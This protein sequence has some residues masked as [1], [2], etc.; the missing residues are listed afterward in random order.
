MPEERRPDP[1]PAHLALGSAG[2][3]AVKRMTP[4]GQDAPV[5][6]P[7]RPIITIVLDHDGHATV[8]GRAV[9]VEH[10]EDP[11][12][13]LLAMASRRAALL[14]RPVRVEARDPDGVWHLAAHPDG[15]VTELPPLP[16]VPERADDAGLWQ[17]RVHPSGEIT[18]VDERLPA[19]DPAQEP[20]PPLGQHG[21]RVPDVDPASLLGDDAPPAVDQV[22]PAVDGDDRPVDDE[23][24]PVDDGG[25]TPADAP[26]SGGDRPAPDRLWSTRPVPGPTATGRS[27]SDLPDLPDLPEPTPDPVPGSAAAPVPDAPPTPM[28]DHWLSMPVDDAPPAVDDGSAAVDEL[29]GVVDGTSELVDDGTPGAGPPSVANQPDDGEQ[30]WFDSLEEQPSHR[31]G[32]SWTQTGDRRPDDHPDGLIDDLRVANLSDPPADGGRRPWLRPVAF[33]GAG[34]VAV[35]AIAA[36]LLTGR[37]PLSTTAQRPTL[38]QTAQVTLG[39]PSGP[40]AADPAPASAPPTLA[41]PPSRLSIGPP[42]GYG[43]SPVWALPISPSATSIVSADGRVLTLTADNQV[44]LVDPLTGAVLWH[45]PVPS[46]AAGPFFSRV[47]GQ[48]VAAVTTEKRLTYWGLPEAGAQANPR[49]T[50]I[51][52]DLPPGTSVSWAGPSP[53]LALGDGGTGVIRSGAIQRVTLP[54]GMRGLAADGADVLAVSGRNWIRQAAGQAP[55]QP[56]QFAAPDGAT[57]TT[58]VRIDNVGGSFL[59]TMWEGAQGPVVAVYDA[60][61][62]DKV[63]QSTFPKGVDFSRA[64]TVREAG[65]E[66]TTVGS[67]LIE[68]AQHNLSVLASSFTPVALTPGHVFADGVSGAVADLQISGK[69]LKV[70]RF[71]DR[72]PTVPVGIVTRDSTSLAIVA[73][74]A[75][76]G[77][78]LCALPKT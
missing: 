73:A 41:T 14:G 30:A 18:P 74:P 39:A 46:G 5:D 37:S 8:D 38:T 55:G 36:V 3:K 26:L 63:V 60:H 10:A 43:A 53:L 19:Q 51:E 34:V 78:L 12:G 47:D 1:C 33:A 7:D 22:D 59:V 9:A 77:W 62:G 45:A 13:V 16:A 28:S 58:P 23:P 67:A 64:P 50:P 70:V 54:T 57:A 49:V 24:D 75:T 48:Q 15:A 29:P 44:A 65:S 25:E 56:Q 68:P 4:H 17:L 21:H 76:S 66:R 11:Q 31:D 32:G 6:V 35:A 71:P 61:R 42:P 40:G 20:S 69:D 27:P 2:T 52:I 72:N